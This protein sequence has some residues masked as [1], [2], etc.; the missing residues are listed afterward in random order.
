MSVLLNYYTEFIKNKKAK[1]RAVAVFLHIVNNFSAP[2]FN[3]LLSGIIIQ[4]ISISFW[5]EYISITL[6]LNLAII[7]LA[8]GNKD[9]L[10]RSFSK[11]P[12][13]IK[14]YWQENLLQRLALCIL[15][16]ALLFIFFDYTL[17]RTGLILLCILALFLYK[18]LEVLVLYHRSFLFSLILELTGY[19]ALLAFAFFY[20]APQLTIDFLLSTFGIITALKL[21]LTAVYFRNDIFPFKKITGFFKFNSLRV[22]IPFFLPALVGL[23]QGKMDLYCTSYF[24]AAT[25]VGKYQVFMNLLTI[26]HALAGFAFMPFLKN[27]YRLPENSLLKIQR[28]VYLLS[29]LVPIPALFF[30]VLIFK[31]YY[32]LSLDPV[33][34]LLGYF[35]LIPFFVYFLLIQLLF[36]RDKQM[37]VTKITLVTAVFNLIASVKLIPSLGIEGAMIANL[38]TQW[39]TLICYFYYEHKAYGR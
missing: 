16:P 17:L 14:S 24:L 1:Q 25:E 28:R 20:P 21:I 12:S 26:P 37:L 15:L 4:R 9:Y 18:S 7:I 11:Q 32:L 33:M 38:A 23:L 2:F 35:Q 3:F 5:G 22:A 10:L 29:F 27:I 8:W 30:I 31:K 6:L 34:Y 39:F 19:T 36:R 13:L